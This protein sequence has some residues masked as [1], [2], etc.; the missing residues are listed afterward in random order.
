MNALAAA[1]DQY[2]LVLTPSQRMALSDII[3]QVMHG[4]NGMR[5]DVFVDVVRHVEVRPGELLALVMEAE[6]IATLEAAFGDD[7]DPSST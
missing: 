1:D 2:V 4:C 3:L 6:T 5:L 7:D